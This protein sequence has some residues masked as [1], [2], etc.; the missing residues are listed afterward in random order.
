[1]EFTKE[2]KDV[3]SSKND[4]RINILYSKKSQYFY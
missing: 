2:E 1:M 4:L 3:I